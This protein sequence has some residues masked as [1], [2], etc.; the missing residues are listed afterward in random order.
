MNRGRGHRSDDCLIKRYGLLP[1]EIRR[2]GRM[3][4]E[5]MTLLLHFVKWRSDGFSREWERI[6]D[7]NRARVF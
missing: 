5:P 2:K 6:I 7:M 3:L 4:N 1:V